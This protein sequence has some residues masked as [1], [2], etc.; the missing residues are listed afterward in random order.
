L[1]TLLQIN[2]LLTCFLLTILKPVNFTAKCTILF[3]NGD[4]VFLHF[5]SSNMVHN[6]LGESSAVT[7]ALAV[8]SGAVDCSSLPG[9]VWT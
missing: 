8:S 9:E 7:V 3:T 4:K 1:L 6:A 5:D 2:D